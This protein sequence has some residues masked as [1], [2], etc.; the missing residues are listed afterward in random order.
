[1]TAK[2]YL[3]QVQKLDVM[4]D[5]LNRRIEELYTPLL[6][7]TA[8]PS[9]EHVDG[10]KDMAGA[11]DAIYDELDRVRRTVTA[12]RL[13]ARLLRTRIQLEILDL[14]DPIHQEILTERYIEHKKFKDIQ[15]PKEQPFEYKYLCKVHGK[16]LQAFADKHP[17]IRY[18]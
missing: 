8:D 7:V 10:S 12:L 6:S 13:Q 18:L 3:L 14:D 5:A 11:H 1:M 4:I 9:K 17:E 15:V 2:D 16:A